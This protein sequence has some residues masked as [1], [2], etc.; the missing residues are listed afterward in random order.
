M[1]SDTRRILGVNVQVLDVQAAIRELDQCIALRKCTRVAF[2]NAN[3]ANLAFTNLTLRQSLDSFLVLNDGLGVDVASLILYKKRF[4]SNL[5]GTD[6]TPKFLDET[7]HD[8]CIALVGGR[9]EVIEQVIKNI[10]RRWPRHRIVFAH[11]GYFNDA[12]EASIAGKIKDAAP[13]VVFVAMGNP[14]QETWIRRNVPTVCCVGLGV[15]ALFDFISGSIP[16][17]PLF[18]RRV[19]LEWLYRL[20]VEPRRLWRRYTIDN[21]L[22]M[23]R[24]LRKCRHPYNYSARAPLD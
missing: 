3:L 2:L 9:L 12:E 17:A 13:D 11:H 16:R 18:I 15:G 23:S 19:R 14:K 10:E 5:N 24:V 22:F 4:P 8:L 1:R 20:M 6:F 7:R 21:L